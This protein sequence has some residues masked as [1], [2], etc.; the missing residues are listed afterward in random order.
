MTDFRI[1]G[2]G[3]AG[4]TVAAELVAQGVKPEVVDPNGGPGEASCSWWAGGML[5]PFCESENAE[6]PVMRV[7]QQ[8]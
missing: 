3:V 2:A 5:A 4:L 8:A 6:E 1:L 7:G